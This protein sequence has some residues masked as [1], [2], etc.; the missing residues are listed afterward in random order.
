MD[1]D[2]DHSRLLAAT[3]HMRRRRPTVLC[4]RLDACDA[5]QVGAQRTCRRQRRV[6]D[7]RIA[8]G[9]PPTA[10]RDLAD[11]RLRLWQPSSAVGPRISRAIGVGGMVA[12]V[13]ALDHPAVFS[14]LTADQSPVRSRPARPTRTS[15]SHDEATM[16]R[17]FSQPMPDW[18]RPRSRWRSS[19]P[20]ALEHRSATTADAARC[21]RRTQLGPHARLHAR[22][23]DGR[24]AGHRCSP[25]STASHAGASD[26]AR[27]E[28]TARRLVVDVPATARIHPVGNGRGCPT[29][30]S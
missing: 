7:R 13:A 6:D 15:P 26:R 11:S 20:R 19:P 17:L 14:T 10:L 12:Q 28:R 27:V 8:G 5:Q 18:T 16:S 3:Q 29:R 25:S 9:V 30:P 22:G 21:D 4:Q 2:F 24:P 23:P 1:D